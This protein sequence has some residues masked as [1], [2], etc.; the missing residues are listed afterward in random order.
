MICRFK[1]VMFPPLSVACMA[2]TL[3]DEPGCGR[4][5]RAMEELSSSSTPV[6]MTDPGHAGQTYE[7]MGADLLTFEAAADEIARATGRQVDT[8]RSQ[9]RSSPPA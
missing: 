1:S 8:T 7:V 4:T 2:R 9:A 5:S 6:V 3:S